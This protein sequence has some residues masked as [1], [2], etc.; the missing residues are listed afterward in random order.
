MQYS[1]ILVFLWRPLYFFLRLNGWFGG[2]YKTK[3]FDGDWLRRLFAFCF[4]SYGYTSL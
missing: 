2:F 4:R 3:R 1:D